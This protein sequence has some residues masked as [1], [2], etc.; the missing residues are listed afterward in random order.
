MLL[1]SIMLKPNSLCI[2]LIS[3]FLSDG[4][5]INNI[6]FDYEYCNKAKY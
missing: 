4:N 1:L 2:V 5:S 6:N 3:K